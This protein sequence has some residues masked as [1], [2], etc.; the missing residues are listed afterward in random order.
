VTDGRAPQ[1]PLEAYIALEGGFGAA[2]AM[3]TQPRIAKLAYIAAKGGEPAGAE[4]RVEADDL[5]TLARRT[6]E[7]FMS[8]VSSFDRESRPYPA[9]RRAL[10][11]ETQRYDDY[12]HL[13]RFA[14]WLVATAEGDAT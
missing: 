8:L 4:S 2:L 6:G 10:F 12:A 13:A 3:Q 1:L 9:L 7:N 14:E 5:N 11:N